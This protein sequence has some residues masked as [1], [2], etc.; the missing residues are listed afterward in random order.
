M[1]T[2]GGLHKHRGLIALIGTFLAAFALSGC[3]HEKSLVPQGDILPGQHT[4]RAF[5][6]RETFPVRQF[7]I[8]PAIIPELREPAPAEDTEDVEDIPSD[9][10]HADQPVPAATPDADPGPTLPALSAPHPTRCW[11]GD[12]TDPLR[13]VVTSLEEQSLLYDTEPLTDCSGIFHRVLLGLKDQCPGR[14]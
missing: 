7:L 8:V 5:Q 3:G 13:A 14:D 12:V 2:H 1:K 10:L 9:Q 11:M 6:K 4:E